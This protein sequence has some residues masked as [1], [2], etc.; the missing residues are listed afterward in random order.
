[1]SPE[2]ELVWVN[3]IYFRKHII[4]N[5]VSRQE[6]VQQAAS[7]AGL[8]QN[9]YKTI[10]RTTIGSV[11]NSVIVYDWNASRFLFLEIE[12][13]FVDPRWGFSLDG[14]QIN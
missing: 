5:L 1:M 14:L 9:D 7:T 6:N 10:I 8:E 4:W 12:L 3:N 13:L 2:S 11:N